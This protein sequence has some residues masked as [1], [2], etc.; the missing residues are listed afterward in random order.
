M[1]YTSRP[2]RRPVRRKDHTPT[3]LALLTLVALPALGY[4]VYKLVLNKPAPPPEDPYALVA[5]APV[6]PPRAETS[7]STSASPASGA[8]NATPDD[9]NPYAGFRGGADTPSSGDPFAAGDGSLTSVN[10][11]T[12][13]ACRKIKESVGLGK[14]LVIWLVDRSPS[15]DGRRE[16]LA[17]SLETMYPLLTPT[18]A[19]SP[20]APPTPSATP[21]PTAVANGTV[22]ATGNAA[23]GAKTEAKPAAKPED[24]PLLSVVAQF[25][26]EYEVLF[27]EPTA[28]PATVVSA[29][30]SIQSGGAGNVENTFKAV[31][32][33]INQYAEYAAAPHRRYITLVVVTDE[34]GNDQADRDASLAAAQ[35][36]QV[37]VFVIG[38][39]A[40]FGSKGNQAVGA[41]GA[42]FQQGPETRE[43]DTPQLESPYAMM[44]MGSQECGIGPYSLVHLCRTSGGEY[45]AVS[46]L[47][48]GM[49]LPPQMMPR[50]LSEAE[51]QK[52]KSGNKALAA[53]FE[54]AALPPAK[55]TSNMRP[56]FGVDE[57]GVPTVTEVDE[58]QRP[59]ALVMPF[60]DKQFEALKKGESDRE[61]LDPRQL[62]VYDLAYG[63]IMAV[64]V[65]HEGYIVLLAA[66]KSGR[67]KMN[68]TSST[69]SLSPAEGIEKNSVLE[70]M[71]KKARAVLQGVVD[72]Y[73]NTPWAAAAQQE[74]SQPIGWAWSES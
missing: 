40:T 36:Y 45:Y 42:D 66:F 68:P 62:A 3:I 32:G 17:Q 60:I 38:Q 21:S 43:L 46:T 12:A 10:A 51:Y 20:G 8:S 6:V 69:F 50:Y 72:R 57:N 61:K 44:S 52:A 64:K 5:A 13:R 58:A 7:S 37:P 70:T 48:G 41:E 33:I 55:T 30:K 28:D 19:P 54:A 15:C 47:G 29:V 2:M 14:S 11:A 26:N 1:S 71:A 4:L 53:L 22:V 39:A 49:T 9:V 24:A 67:K 35:K 65:R 74:L 18:A 34:V 56:S 63:R 31:T 23:E 25:S 73:P 16:E 59:V 27:T